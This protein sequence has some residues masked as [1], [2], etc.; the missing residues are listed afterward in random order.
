MPCYDS[1]DDEDKRDNARLVSVLCSIISKHGVDILK[2]VDWK[3]AGVSKEFTL[4]WWEL[5]LKQDIERR[6][7]EKRW[8]AE[9]RIA[10]ELAFEMLRKKL[11]K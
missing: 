5:H 8:A 1:R 11:G 9:K 3:E 6:A 7:R 2:D 10:D 4:K